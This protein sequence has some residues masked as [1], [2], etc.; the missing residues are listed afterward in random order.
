[1]VYLKISWLPVFAIAFIVSLILFPKIAASA[2]LNGINLWLNVVFPSLFPFFVASQLLSKSGFI[3]LFGSILEPIMRP[4]FNVPGTG[5]FALAMGIVSGYPIGATITS[6]LRKQKLI[7]KTEAERLLTF[8][9][10]SGP[11]FIMGAVAVGMFNL[12]SAGYLLYASHVAA[13]LTVGFIFKFYKRKREKIPSKKLKIFQ[14]LNM[15]L[16]NLRKVD[17]NPWT[18]FGECI[19]N[20]IFIILNIGGFIIFFSVLINILITS[21]LVNSICS[22]VPDY[23]IQLGIDSKTIEG[24]FCGLFEIT[25]GS[26]LIDSASAALRIKLSAASLIIGWA[27]FSVHAQVMSIVSTTDISVKPYILGKAIQGIISGIYTY[28]GYNFFYKLLE[29]APAFSNTFEYTNKWN[30][31]FKQSL[32]NVATI[33]SIMMIISI[34]Y[35]YTVKIISNKR[36]L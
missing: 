25:T 10:N 31:L 32:Q 30:M 27:G 29:N 28:I 24:L 6:D 16:E 22:L 2:A 12:P 23:I 21:G 15:E 34:I 11:L 4:V 14:R 1:M 18:L 19:K 9:N 5:S 20:S 8:T 26:N 17:I 13:C 33:A 7:T 35:V 36:L 3:N